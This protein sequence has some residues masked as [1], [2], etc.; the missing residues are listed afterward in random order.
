M[1]RTIQ[2]SVGSRRRWWTQVGTTRGQ[3]RLTWRAG[4]RPL[5]T[6]ATRW[7]TAGTRA[8]QQVHQSPQPR[9]PS[10]RRTASRGA[11]RSAA[12]ASRAV[13]ATYQRWRPRLPRQASKP[14]VSYSAASSARSQTGARAARNAKWLAAQS[15]R[16]CRLRPRLS[17][18]QSPRSHGPPSARRSARL[19]CRGA[20]PQ[21]NPQRNLATPRP[22]PRA[23]GVGQSSQ[24]AKLE[25]RRP[26]LM[27]PSSALVV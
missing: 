10:G 12:R 8:T 9:S 19:V 3:P 7:T 24:R 17:S 16:A 21:T 25:P 13:R 5:R 14:C 15:A 2:V 22:Q 18:R 1:T 26:P 27:I 4:K 11:R 20:Q 6:R 23:L